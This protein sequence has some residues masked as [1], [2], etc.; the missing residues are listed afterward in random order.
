MIKAAV[1][2]DGK[3][4]TTR[5]VIGVD[6]I[7]LVGRGEVADVSGSIRCLAGDPFVGASED[8]FH[9]F[10]PV[11]HRQLATG[12]ARFHH[13][14][15]DEQ[16]EQRLEPTRI[17]VGVVSGDEITDALTGD[18]VVQVH[19][20]DTR[21]H[22]CQKSR[23]RRP[24]DGST[25]GMDRAVRGGESAGTDM[26][27]NCF[28]IGAPR[29]GTT[30]LYEYLNAHPDVYMSPVKEPDFFSRP[31]LDAVEATD[32]A[33]SPRL[34]DAAR[35]DPALRADFEEYAALF[36][37][38]GHEKIV[39]EAS[40]VYLGHPAAAHHLRR[41]VPEAKLIAI[42]R[43]PAQRAHSHF[44]HAQRIYA[45]YERGALDDTVTR[46]I[47]DE[48]N[49]VIDEAFRNGPPEPAITDP[50]VWVRSG[51]YHQH[52]T[53]FQALFPAD[54]LIVFL[55]EDL[56]EDA[57]A[58]MTAIFRFLA[59]DDTFTLPSTAAFNAS[60]V[61]RSRTVFRFFT[62]RNPVMR[63]A[64]AVAPTRLRDLAMRSRNRLLAGEK[65]PLDPDQRAKL[66]AIYH[67]DIERLQELL[68]R[69]LSS[70]LEATPAAA[71]AST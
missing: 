47:A 43:D 44:V 48:F 29:S 24:A 69:D 30:S 12:V 52:L 10:P 66:I 64:R 11:V 54:Q 39:G 16:L 65:P 37:K 22:S 25:I 13:G 19:A 61:P 62:T 28:V 60:V 57:Q 35:S 70:W 42:L 21:R 45:E 53:R 41:Y 9:V 4:E 17:T 15:L 71:P 2:Q 14:V 50:Q 20:A 51:F 46:S 63:Y 67:D 26:L 38:V 8:P 32:D 5:G 27:P 31:S 56:V 33:A 68:G 49:Q 3:V 7:D 36:A 1:H 55:Y 58:L 59:I 23:P 34:E 18:H 6:E 40:A